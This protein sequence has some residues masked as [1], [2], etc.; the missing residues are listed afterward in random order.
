M[1]QLLASFGKQGANLGLDQISP[2]VEDSKQSSKYFDVTEFNPVFT[3]GKNSVSFNG[4]PY[5]APNSE[6]RIECLDNEGNSL[7]VEI[8]NPSANYTDMAKF[9]VSVSV[10]ADTASGPGLFILVGTLTTGLIV[11][12]KANITI[13]NTLPSICRTRFYNTPTL[14]VRPL[15]YP[16]IDS[17]SGSLLV[18]SSSV[19]SRCS[20]QLLLHVAHPNK[21][22][23][24]LTTPTDTF[25]S[26]MVGQTVELTYGNSTLIYGEATNIGTYTLSTGKFG[27][28][29]GSYVIQ[30]VINS[31]TIV[32]PTLYYTFGLPPQKSINVIITTF[33]NGKVN[34]NYTPV[35]YFTGSSSSS[36]QQYIN[37]QGSASLLQKSYV[38]V[39]YRNIGTFS[40]LV[41]RHKLYA[42]SNI[43]PG[44]FVVIDDATVGPSE[45]LTDPITFNK[46]YSDIGVFSN[47]DQINQYWFP[48]SA[49][50]TLSQSNVPFLDSLNIVA[51]PT[52]AA[53]D[54][55]SYVIAKT[56][57][58]RLLNDSVYYPYDEQGYSD[59]SGSGYASNFIFLQSGVLY[60]LT[61][62][63][64]VQKDYNA[65]AKIFFYLTSSSP[66]VTN[67]PTYN[68]KYGILMGEIDVSGPMTTKTFSDVQQ[69][70]F[71]PLNDYYGT[72]VIVPHMC[73]VTLANLSLQ[74]YGDYGFSPGAVVVQLPFPINVANES[75]TL[76]AELY[77][78][79][80][81][82][83]YS[84]TPVVQTFDPYGQS[85]FGSSILGSG[86]TGTPTTLPVLTVTGNFI[87]PNVSTCGIST[88]NRVL[89]INTSTGI[90]CATNVVGLSLISSPSTNTYKDYIELDMANPT[91]TG[92]SLVIHYNG[93][94]SEGKRIVILANGSK[95]I[96][97]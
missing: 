11:R 4:S 61:T 22:G 97:S 41:A 60:S 28:A 64:V 95:T 43:Y 7:F 81:N 9:T 63:V 32:I 71:T 1:D 58:F 73:S 50:L 54:G 78:N 27:P 86:G 77:D 36:Y 94:A 30:Q 31:K 23:T 87:L 40:G 25:T 93:I 91:L 56:S 46:T 19:S 8:P 89:G 67:E 85:L 74:N 90:V 38:D 83:I 18:S 57:A 96:Y 66:N 82:L 6:I 5:L 59:F 39:L 49:S 52:N 72:L 15:L 48:S 3:A 75:F 35:S 13:N 26:Q 17:A 21:P 14:E 12:W 10:F 24:Y 65:S 29:S 69:F 84:L 20:G 79:N 51:T 80:S 55:N 42:K 47:Q 33:S 2:D 70:L 53:A 88:F 34:I 68:S 92:R 16:V 37:A 76:K 45:L 44:D 62:N